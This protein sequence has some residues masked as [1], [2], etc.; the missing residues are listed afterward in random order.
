MSH[1]L[2]LVVALCCQDDKGEQYYKFAV[3]TTW[4]FKTL[5][6]GKEAKQI[7]TVKKHDGE[8]VV[9]ETKD[10]KDGKE[11]KVETLIW[12]VQT[13]ILIWSQQK[14]DKTE[15][16]FNLYKLGSKKG[17]TWSGETGQ[18]PPGTKMSHEGVE[19]L[20]TAAGTYKDA[21]KLKLAATISMGDKEMKLEASFWIVPNVGLAKLHMQMDDDLMSLELTEFKAAK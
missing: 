2:L 12:E 20:K 19:E 11:D 7:M 18:M 8:K 15:L 17:D 13:G 5:E 4:T 3:G 16:L 14:D 9:V 1:A 10:I 6:R 21:V